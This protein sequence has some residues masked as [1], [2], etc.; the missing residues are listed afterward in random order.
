MTVGGAA[1]TVI[2]DRFFLVF[3]ISVFYLYLYLCLYLASKDDLEVMFVTDRAFK[4]TFL[5]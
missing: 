2:L 3:A 5:M 4:L 1:A